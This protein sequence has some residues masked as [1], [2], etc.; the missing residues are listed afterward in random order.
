MCVEAHY[1]WMVRHEFQHTEL[2]SLNV[3]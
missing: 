1:I 2:V 3:W